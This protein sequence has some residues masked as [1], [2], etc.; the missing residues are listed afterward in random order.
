MKKERAVTLNF[1]K[2]W[3]SYYKEYA[4]STILNNTT[5]DKGNIL[6]GVA[7]ITFED[8]TIQSMNAVNI[9]R[10]EP[11]RLILKNCTII[12]YEKIIGIENCVIK[13]CT[14][15]KPV[16]LVCPEDGEF[17]AYKKCYVY[18]HLLNI[19]NS[20]YCIVKLLIPA[21]AKRS[22]G[23]RRK[24]RCSKARVLGIYDLDGAEIEYI[25]KAYS[26]HF[27][28]KIGENVFSDRLVYKVGEEVYPDSFDENRYNE[29]SYGIH[30][31]MTFEEAA[32][33]DFT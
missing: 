9:T 17:V 15:V 5:I 26:H 25:D 21:D 7:N 11:Y 14:F 30:F 8:C 18:S 27:V 16:P 4:I 28:Y 31:F 12:D 19:N 6:V 13:N 33:Y 1:V 29:C 20:A 10:G 3:Q 32:A 2:P 23:F 24:C 22:S